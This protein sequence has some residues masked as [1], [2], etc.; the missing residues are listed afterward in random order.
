MSIEQGATRLAK[1]ERRIPQAA[2]H[3]PKTGR[4]LSFSKA[5]IRSALLYTS[6][7]QRLAMTAE[8]ATIELPHEALTEH[9]SQAKRVAFRFCFLYFGLYCIYTQI[10]TALISIPN[11][12]IGDPSAYWPMRQ[13]V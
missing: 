5:V 3:A 12:E 13:I 9:W 8:V 11:M 6:T 1:P 7:R 10:S 2:N 4:P